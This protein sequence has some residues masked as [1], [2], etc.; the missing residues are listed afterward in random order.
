[1]IT[2]NMLKVV[3]V[4]ADTMTN[5]AATAYKIAIIN[6]KTAPIISTIVDLPTSSILLPAIHN[7]AAKIRTAENTIAGIDRLPL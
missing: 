7:S 1:M 2:T 4:V 5:I 6:N 3:D